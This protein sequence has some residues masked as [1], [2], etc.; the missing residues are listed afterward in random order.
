[1]IRLSVRDASVA[2]GRKKE[3]WQQEMRGTKLL[4]EGEK[5]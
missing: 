1:M 4:G 3:D 5:R 2:A